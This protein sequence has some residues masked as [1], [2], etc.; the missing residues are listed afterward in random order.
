[1]GK[2]ILNKKNGNDDEGIN[3]TTK[4]ASLF[5]LGIMILSM[6]GFA[7]MSGG[8]FG[9]GSNDNLP[10]NVD[11]QKFND[12]T[13]GQE[14]WGA[15]KNSEQFIFMTIDGYDN[16]TVMANLADEVKSYQSI[17]I[18]EDTDFESPDAL[19]LFEKSLRGLSIPTQRIVDV[20]CN[21]G[22]IIF[23]HNV[24][25]YDGDCMIFDVPE[26]EE[27]IYSEILTYHLIK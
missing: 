4:V 21:A 8:G 3:T 25:N 17:T 16:N 12:Q 2:E 23:T 26:G 7:L 15:I 20:N 24:S 19:F 27:H 11:F 5:I 6:G 1:M 9:S 22:T 10:S 14:F 18:F 13:T